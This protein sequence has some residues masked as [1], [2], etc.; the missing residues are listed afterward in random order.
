[1]KNMR[2]KVEI[3]AQ[4]YTTHIDVYIQKQYYDK[5][6]YEMIGILKHKHEIQVIP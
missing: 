2:N 4:Y 3:Y 5:K 1:M 6:N